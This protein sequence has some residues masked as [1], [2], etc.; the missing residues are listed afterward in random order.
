MKYIFIAISL[1]FTLTPV[2][3]QMEFEEV[4]QLYPDDGDTGFNQIYLNG[5]SVYV[6]SSYSSPT[7]GLVGH[8]L[9]TDGGETWEDLLLREKL[10][11]GDDTPNYSAFNPYKFHFIERNKEDSSFAIYNFDGELI[12]KNKFDTAPYSGR[13]IFNPIDPN[14][15][16]VLTT[17]R[18]PQFNVY[19]DNFYYS[20]DYG[21]N[22][23]KLDAYNLAV[24]HSGIG[25]YPQKEIQFLPNIRNP[26]KSIFRLIWHNRITSIYHFTMNYNFYTHEAR[27]YE[28]NLQ[29]YHSDYGTY[30]EDEVV[31]VTERDSIIHLNVETGEKYG[32]SRLDATMGWDPDSIAQ[33]NDDDFPPEYSQL[34]ILD[35]FKI[36]PTNPNHQVVMYKH[37]EGIQ[38]QEPPMS[39]ID[40]YIFQSFDAGQTW[41]SVA[42]S[43]DKFNP[44]VDI[45][46]NPKDA[47]LWIKKN[48][49]N[50]ARG[51]KVND[52]YSVLYKSTSPLT[53][54]SELE[55]NVNNISALFSGNSLVIDSKD[56]VGDASIKL[57]NIEGRKV[58]ESNQYIERGRNEININANVASG[59]Y[60]VRIK[61][62]EKETI[63]KLIRSK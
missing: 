61:T 22:W 23:Y 37:G 10:K 7:K 33:N 26:E 25:L 51:L 20:N 55:S 48:D 17:Y 47:T 19:H 38:G 3:S 24:E 1:L 44:I 36:N 28:D 35:K 32:Y 39:Y 30:D 15:I 5:D 11:L 18:V 50:G 13:I 56:L 58:L 42:Q 8:L 45:Y 59:L 53:N 4:L 29:Y 60:L 41:E 27:F 62:R 63:V 14:F 31:R 57:F 2:Y 21:K 12:S 49:N 43:F 9:S 40:Q 34:I 6:W 54:V 16:G 46:I 52:H